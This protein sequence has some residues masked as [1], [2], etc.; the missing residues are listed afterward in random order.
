VQRQVLFQEEQDALAE[1][2]RICD[3]MQ[4]AQ[5]SIDEIREVG[6]RAGVP[7]GWLR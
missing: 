7:A 5:E 6:R 4:A 1:Q 2:A 3:A